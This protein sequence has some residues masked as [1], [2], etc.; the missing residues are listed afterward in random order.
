MSIYGPIL[1][2]TPFETESKTSMRERLA[3]VQSNPGDEPS[4]MV[5]GL[6]STADP[7]RTLSG[8]GMAE[9]R[10]PAHPAVPRDAAVGPAEW[11]CSACTLLNRPRLRDLLALRDPELCGHRRV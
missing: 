1:S 5:S 11:A 2:K 6:D 10:P 3:A 9:P 8:V 4:R 7:S